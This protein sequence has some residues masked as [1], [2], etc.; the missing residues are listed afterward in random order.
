MNDIELI[1][2]NIG[3]DGLLAD[4]QESILSKDKDRLKVLIELKKNIDKILNVMID[5]LESEYE[6]VDTKGIMLLIESKHILR[7]VD[8][9][10][11]SI[12]VRNEKAYLRTMLINTYNEVK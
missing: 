12:G 9:Y 7:I 2:C 3:Y 6:E 1:K 11:N 5:V 10:T 4:I 8:K